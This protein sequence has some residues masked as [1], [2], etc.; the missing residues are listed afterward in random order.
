M[1]F[2]RALQAA[3][4]AS[5]P[6]RPFLGV[7]SAF[8]VWGCSAVPAGPPPGPPEPSAYYVEVGDS[9]ADADEIEALLAGYR[10]EME[11]ELAEVLGHA[12]GPFVKADPEGALD[13]LVAEAVLHV[14]RQ[15]VDSAVH[16]A[17]LNDGGLRVPLASGPLLMTHAFELLPFRNYLTLLTLSGAEMEQLADQI[18]RSRGEPVAGW[19]MALDGEDAVDVRIGG[20]PVDPDAEYLLVTV[21]YLVDGG[22]TWSVLWGAG[23]GRRQNTEI[24]IRDA[25]AAYLREVGEVSPDL[26][27]DR[28]IRLAG[29]PAGTHPERPPR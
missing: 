24:L 15:E 7:A 28:R 27:L 5:R 11:E 23:P 4:Q 13:N 21:D 8:L 18:A 10:A 20:E 17:L 14:A 1:N 19:T 2:P 16:A 6:R 22:G 9:I 12:T 26:F 25:F 3:R 29:A